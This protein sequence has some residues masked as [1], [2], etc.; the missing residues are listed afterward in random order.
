MRGVNW[1][2]AFLI[3]DMPPNDLQAVLW[4]VDNST[5]LDRP[6]EGAWRAHRG[7]SL[8]RGASA[9]RDA[10]LLALLG[11]DAAGEAD[12]VCEPRQRPV[13]AHREDQRQRHE[14]HS[15]REGRAIP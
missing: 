4:D 9:A 7:G 1:R 5:K 10:S 2:M 3:G 6:G 13:G 11:L 12:A 14:G 15:Q 8:T